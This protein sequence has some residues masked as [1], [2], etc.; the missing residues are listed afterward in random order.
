M[1]TLLISQMVAN[2]GIVEFGTLLESGL[3]ER[4]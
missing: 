1:L 3:R 4:D 2:A